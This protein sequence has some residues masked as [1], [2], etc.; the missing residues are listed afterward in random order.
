MECCDNAKH[1]DKEKNIEREPETKNKTLIWIM[2]GV[3]FLAAIFFAFK[4]GSSTVGTSDLGL[5][6]K[7]DTTGWTTNEI[8]NYE[9]HG[10]I[11]PRA[12]K[13]SATTQTPGGMVGGC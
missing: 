5:S 10:T 7:I 13:I 3:L 2:I 11:P 8:M 4:L 12:G 6:G 1:E 9:M